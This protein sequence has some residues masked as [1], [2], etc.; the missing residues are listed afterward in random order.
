MYIISYIDVYFPYLGF[1]FDMCI[2]CQRPFV[3]LQGKGGINFL[4]YAA[5]QDNID[6]AKFEKSSSNGNIFGQKDA[7]DL[8]FGAVSAEITQETEDFFVSEAEGDPD[9]PSE[10]YSS[11][12]EAINALRKGKVRFCVSLVSL[13]KSCKSEIS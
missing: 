10:G 2:R 8:S 1:R 11:I 7:K 4:A 9:Q 13:N 3:G 6:G 12:D 5:S